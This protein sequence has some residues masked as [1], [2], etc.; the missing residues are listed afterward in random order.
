MSRIRF[1]LAILYI[2]SSLLSTISLAQL[3]N[4]CVVRYRSSSWAARPTRA[5]RA[6]RASRWRTSHPN[7]RRTAVRSL[8][9]P[10]PCRH[11]STR[12]Q[13]VTLCSL[14]PVNL[15]HSFELVCIPVRAVKHFETSTSAAHRQVLHE[16]FVYLASKM[17]APPGSST[18]IKHSRSISIVLYSF[19]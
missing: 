5:L 2:F 11:T 10:W 1:A 8:L 14:P 7:S 16:A 15:E 19:V 4:L 17:S 3:T 9:C 13:T 18:T 12:P 6:T